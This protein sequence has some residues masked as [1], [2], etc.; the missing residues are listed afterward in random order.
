MLAN[1]LFLLAIGI[2]II[3][4]VWLGIFAAKRARTRAG[5]DSAA[6]WQF[7]NSGNAEF[8]NRTCVSSDHDR[9]H[10]GSHAD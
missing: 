7:L 8:V 1:T 10:S 5:D 6:T 9:S 2:F 3:G 4:L